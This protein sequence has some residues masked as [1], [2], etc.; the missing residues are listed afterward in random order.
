MTAGRA[1]RVI[2]RR[3]YRR[4]YDA[5]RTLAAFGA[6]LR[7]DVELDALTEQLLRTV[8][9]TMQ[10]SSVGLWIKPGESQAGRGAARGV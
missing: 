2:D 8:D 10:P 3:F 4:R 9:E 1:Q 7:D 5:T 6:S